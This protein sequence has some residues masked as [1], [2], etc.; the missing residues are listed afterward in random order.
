MQSMR[1]NNAFHLLC[2]AGFMLMMGVAFMA[3]MAPA[4][5]TEVVV[6]QQQPGL[7]AWGELTWRAHGYLKHEGDFYKA[8]ERLEVC[9]DLQAYFCGPV[10]GNT[11]Q[12]CFIAFCTLHDGSSLCAGAVVGRYGVGQTAYIAPCVHWYVKA[13]NCQVTYSH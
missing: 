5:G 13:A 11:E 6:Q 8:L 9:S 7:P 10:S 1:M 4:A 3:L 12:S 2:M